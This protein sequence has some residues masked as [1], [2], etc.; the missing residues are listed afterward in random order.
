VGQKLVGSAIKVADSTEVYGFISVI[1]MH[2]YQNKESIQQI[3]KYL[4]NKAPDSEIQGQLRALMD[5]SARPLGLILN[6]RMVNVPAELAPQL[7]KS[8]FEEIARA[9]EEDGESDSFNF[10]SYVLVTNLYSYSAG[11]KGSEPTTK[12]AKVGD[13]TF[14]FKVEDESYTQE[15]NVCFTFP[16]QRCEQSSRWTLDGMMAESRMVVVVPHA[17]VSQLLARIS[18]LCSGV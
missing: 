11:E 18:C 1:N 3:W 2:K 17:R 14:Y 12:K 16:M 5:D 4:L 13:E 7:H 15:A 9:Q 8:L 6:E 10:G